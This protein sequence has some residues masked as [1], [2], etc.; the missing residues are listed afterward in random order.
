VDDARELELRVFVADPPLDL[1][2]AVFVPLFWEPVD[3]PVPPEADR[4]ED[5]LDPPDRDEP[6]DPPD[7]ARDEVDDFERAEP[8][9]VDFLVL[10]GEP[11]LFDFAPPLDLEEPLADRP[12]LDAVAFEEADRPDFELDP[13]EPPDDFPDDERLDEALLEPDLLDDAFFDPVGLFDEERPD[14]P[15][16]LD[17]FVVDFEPEDFLVEDDFDPEDFLED[18]DF[19]PEDFLVAAMILIPRIIFETSAAPAST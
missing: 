6:D 11:E 7:F 18:D 14:E 17:F 16:L 19:D 15:E 4:D 8:E 9:D 2:R 1:V 10:E 3:R 5:D 12:D 13:F